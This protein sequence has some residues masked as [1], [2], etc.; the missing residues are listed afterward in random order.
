MGTQMVPSHSFS[1][2]SIAGLLARCAESREVGPAARP[3]GA[4][5]LHPGQKH[6]AALSRG[7]GS[8]QGVVKTHA[9]PSLLVGPLLADWDFSVLLSR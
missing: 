5:F 3:L 4:L 7:P 8:G 9:G 2:E 1:S 6:R